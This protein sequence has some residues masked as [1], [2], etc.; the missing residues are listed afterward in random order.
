MS[1]KTF[2]SFRELKKFV[3]SSTTIEVDDPIISTMVEKG[4]EMDEYISEN[5][6]WLQDKYSSSTLF[7]NAIIFPFLTASLF[8]AIRFLPGPLNK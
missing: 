1:E 8:I 6:H 4:K 3:E 2:N 7:H 5:I